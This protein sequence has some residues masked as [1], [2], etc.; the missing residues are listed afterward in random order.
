MCACQFQ[1]PYIGF[2]ESFKEKLEKKAAKI[3]LADLAG[4]VDEDLDGTKLYVQALIDAIDSKD[5]EKEAEIR[6]ALKRNGTTDQAITQNIRAL[7][8]AEYTG[9]TKVDDYYDEYVKRMKAGD[10]TAAAK[11]NSILAAAVKADSHESSIKDALSRDAEFQKGVNAKLSGDYTTYQNMVKKYDN[12]GF[13]HDV[14]IKATNLVENR[15]KT[16]EKKASG[17]TTETASKSYGESYGYS[18]NDMR[19]AYTDGSYDS[20][21]LVV[22]DLRLQGK[23]DTAIRDE[24]T[25]SVKPIYL[26]LKER[27]P[28]AA[29]KYKQQLI[30]LGIGYTEKQIKQW[31][32][33]KKAAE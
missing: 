22:D 33:T 27:D 6:A 10:K 30:A 2:S 28:A 4:D 14:L 20:F 16:E 12:M 31:K 18:Y 19:S 24:L 26:E 7:R 5:T 29:E 25:K 32:P 13:D 8:M 23:K 3:Q 1:I 17:E 9:G 21:W 15:V 11:I